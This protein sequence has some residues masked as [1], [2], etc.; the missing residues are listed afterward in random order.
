[1]KK[2]KSL[3]KKIRRLEARLQKGEKKLARLKEKLGAA[4]T[5]AAAKPKGKSTGVTQKASSASASIDKNKK[6]SPLKTGAKPAA[7]VKESD[8][9]KSGRR[10][11]NLT[12][13]RREQL[14]AAMRARWAAKRAAAGTNTPD[15]SG[16]QPGDTSRPQ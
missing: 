1:M 9:G 13:E 14:A 6:R 4:E 5:R 8:A 3:Q 2:S 12:P 7:A 15:S 16:P 11:L 10:K